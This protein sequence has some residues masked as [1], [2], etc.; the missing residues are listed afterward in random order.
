MLLWCAYGAVWLLAAG[1]WTLAAAAG[2]ERSPLVALPYGLLQMAVAGV[3]GVGVIRLTR[4][5]PLGGRRGRFV[6]VHAAALAAYASIYA[7]AFVL[8]DVGRGELAAAVSAIARSPVLL[9][10]LLMGSWL[11]LVIAG[12]AYAAGAHRAAVAAAAAAAEARL[13]ARTAQLAALRAQLNPHFLFNALHSVASLMAYD[14][15]AADAA[16]ERVGDL[17][18]YALSDD[19][20]VPLAS[21]WAF[22]QDYLELER[23]RLGDRLRT[24]AHLDPEALPMLVPALLLQPLVE[25]AVRH[26]IDPRPEGGRVAV[27]AGV[28]GGRLVLR[29][30]DDGPG[31]RSDSGSGN[32]VG[33]RSVR[34]RLD[35]RHGD[36]AAIDVAADG[37]AGCVVTISLPLARARG[38]AT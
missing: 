7:T 33:L 11:Y 26:G 30:A 6:A 12:I 18:R 1:I 37:A 32:G 17:L 28:E 38:A 29:V 27:S 10:N 24:E 22:T 35:A 23:L 8:P 3:L 2:A 15:A 31:M 19:D 16:L 5:V 20:E 25:N 4:R 13:Q 36:R 14:V 9:W 21:E 34:R